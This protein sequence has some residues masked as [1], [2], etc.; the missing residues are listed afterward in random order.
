[1]YDTGISANMSRLELYEYLLSGTEKKKKCTE[2]LIS[3]MLVQIN[4]YNT[5][6]FKRRLHCFLWLRYSKNS[7]LN[8]T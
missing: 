7:L 3:T 6:I 8:R 5:W 1:M 4:N 2:N